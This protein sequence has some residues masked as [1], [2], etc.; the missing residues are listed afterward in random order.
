MV[1]FGVRVIVLSKGAEALVDEADYDRFFP[2]R[3]YL[4]GSGK[5]AYAAR[6][7]PQGDPG[8]GRHIIMH[9]EVC[10]AEPGQFVD[11]INGNTLDNRR[12]NL[13]VCTNAENIRNMLPHDGGTSKFKGV[14]WLEARGKWRAQIMHDYK[15]LNLGNYESEEEAGRAYDQAAIR[16]F[17]QFARLNFPEPSHA[18]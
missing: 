12:M 1:D 3:W 15:K 9:R 4:H 7:R 6:N 14:Y 17:G 16:L 13:R 2:H 11:H 10:G 8:P 18:S 5:W